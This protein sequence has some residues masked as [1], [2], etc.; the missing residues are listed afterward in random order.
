MPSKPVGLHEEAL[1]GAKI[2]FEWYSAQNP[3]AAEAFINELD[4]AIEQIGR[5]P[6]LAGLYVSGT[7]RYVMR[8]FPFIVV[9]R[10]QER[11]SNW[12]QLPTVI[13]SQDIGKSDSKK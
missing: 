6:N 5:L 4:Q 10:G 2:A 11:S 7:R 12:S 8:R 3:A 13:A 1:A 9:Y